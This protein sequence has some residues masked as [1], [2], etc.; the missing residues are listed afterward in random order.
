VVV[1]PT[2]FEISGEASHGELIL[3]RTMILKRRVSSGDATTMPLY[4]VDQGTF[5]STTHLLIPI[6][7][8]LEDFPCFA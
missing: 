5:R 7:A 2:N 1:F 8:M 4:L 3:E 6:R